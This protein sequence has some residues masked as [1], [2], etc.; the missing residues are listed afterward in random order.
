MTHVVESALP[1]QPRRRV[2]RTLFAPKAYYFCYY[3]A[4]ACLVPFLTLYY[5]ETGLSGTQI[6]LLTGL[7][8]LVTWI[9]A[10]VW[11][12]VADATRRYRAILAVTITGAMAAV[13]FLSRATELAQLLPIVAVYAFFTAPIMPLVDNSVMT[14]LGE[15][16]DLYGRQRIWGAIGWGLAGAA[17]GVAVAQVGLG[18]SFY[19]FVLM[20]GL[21][22]VVSLRLDVRSGAM[23]R[24]FWKGVGTMVR[25]PAL[26]VFLIAVLITSMGA[27]VVNSFLFLYMA[28]L[29]ATE[30]LMG[31]SLTVAT[32][33]ELP[34]FFFSGGLLRKIGA[35]GL[36]LLAMGAYVVRLLAYSIMPN[37][38]WTLPI[39]LLHGLSFSGMWVA[40]VS[41]ANV[42]APKGFGATAQGLFTGVTM[43]IGAA[44]G[45]V[46]GG[47]LYDSVGPELMFRTAAVWVALGLL[48]FWVAGRRPPVNAAPSG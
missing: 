34:V 29:G 45:A 4:M 36:L 31:L 37:V 9:A 35:R 47:T 20:M 38:W 2:D 30:R 33:S 21:G 42:V 1:V 28:D 26:L 5:R 18:F 41:Y 13:V 24:P 23:S 16:S 22:L 44:A 40:G 11:G 46:L 15:R 48:F 17:A 19:A 3:A 39:N 12:A 10:P 32:L 14:M 6:G 25:T 8:P 27:S 43:G 7:S